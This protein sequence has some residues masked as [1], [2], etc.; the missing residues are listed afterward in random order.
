[1]VDVRPKSQNQAGLK[2]KKTT[3]AIKPK[4]NHGRHASEKKNHDMFKH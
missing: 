2:K 3:M 1:M 4:K